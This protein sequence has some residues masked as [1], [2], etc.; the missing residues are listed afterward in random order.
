MDAA[1]DY[2]SKYS[3]SERERQIPY[4]IIFMWNLKYGNLGFVEENTNTLRM[5]NNKVLLYTTGNCS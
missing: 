5:I 1:R 2:H 3:K 4:D